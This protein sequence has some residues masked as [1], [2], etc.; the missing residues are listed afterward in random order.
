M[1]PGLGRRK[2]LA[3]YHDGN[4]SGATTTAPKALTKLAAIISYNIHYLG[5]T[6]PAAEVSVSYQ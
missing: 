2:L 4:L 6:N 3:I 1:N 5:F